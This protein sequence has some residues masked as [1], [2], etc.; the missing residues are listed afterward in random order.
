LVHTQ[1]LLPKVN[2]INFKGDPNSEYKLVI[3]KEGYTLKTKDYVLEEL[4][5]EL[6]GSPLVMMLS[7]ASTLTLRVDEPTTFG[8]H[9][10]TGSDNIY[11]DWGDGT[12]EHATV[13]SGYFIEVMHDFPENGRFHINITGDLNSINEYYYVFTDYGS[14]QRETI[15]SIDITRLSELRLYQSQFR[16]LPD[17]INFSGNPKLESLSISHSTNISMLDI[18]GNPYLKVLTFAGTRIVQPENP[19]DMSTLVKIINDLHQH[20]IDKNLRD[21]N[22]QY[23]RWFGTVPADANA[24]LID[25]ENNYGW[26][27]WP[28]TY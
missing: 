5:D 9:L 3:E 22:F 8:L 23:V 13:T 18:S 7:P 19:G 27:V 1:N 17:E 26:F 6:D 24:K 12:V 10:K 15:E 14:L 28:D 21:G 4:I 11:I 20:V 16:N 25:L 2:P